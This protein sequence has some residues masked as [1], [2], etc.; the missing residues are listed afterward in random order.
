MG[1]S[2]LFRA[3]YISLPVKAQS[4]RANFKANF[5]ANL[6]NGLLKD[7][8]I[9]MEQKYQV[10][11]RKSNVTHLIN[12]LHREEFLAV[13]IMDTGS[14]ED[15][16]CTIDWYRE[17]FN[18]SIHVITRADRFPSEVIHNKYSDVTFII[19]DK[20]PS[21]AERANSLANTCMTTYFLL[22]RSDTDLVDL[23]WNGLSSIFKE[24]NHPVCI[25]PIVFN[26]DKEL[27]PTVRAPHFKDQE[28]D[29][30][31]FMPSRG[32]DSTLY[33]F[34]GVG[35]YDRAL[36]QRLR[37]YDELL[38]GAFWQ[39]MDFG[40]RCWLY[41]YPLYSSNDLVFIFPNKQFLV[42]DRS[43]TKNAERFYTK[44]LGVKLVRGRVHIKKAYRTDKHVLVS[45]VKPKM[46]L[47]KTDYAK[48]EASWKIPE[49]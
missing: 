3:N 32:K 6:S 4:F 1:T 15:L 5:K 47:Y 36:F 2:F 14:K 35:I 29:P 17:H 20:S 28:I 46:S 9:I 24:D 11:A 7:I 45:E 43:E 12:Q 8:L 48:L 37:G 42:E 13:G 10:I 38:N 16:E 23:N 39:A 25:S 18:Y 22:V 40:T 27:V 44:A 49:N 41:G 21:L 19:F 31:S 34:L 30:M 26:K 33:P